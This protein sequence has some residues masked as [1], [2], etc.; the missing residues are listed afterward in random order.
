MPSAVVDPREAICAN[1]V[2]VA[3]LFSAKLKDY[4][5]VMDQL[6]AEVTGLGGNV[7]GRF[8]QRRGI[9]EHRKGRSSGGKA[10]MD[11]PCSSQ[12]LMT[13][14][15]VREIAAA[16]AETDASAVV[17]ANELTERQRRALTRSLGCPV[18]GKKGLPVS[19]TPT[20]DE[21]GSWRS[22]ETGPG[23]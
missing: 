13:T 4:D 7:V 23:G 2:V 11:R 6:A 12:T 20:K 5:E 15:K 18:F 10:N 22:S 14:G 21:T 19:R 9:S 16:V 1:G 17:F 3:G 8:V